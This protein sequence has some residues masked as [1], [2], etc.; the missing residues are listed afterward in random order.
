MAKRCSEMD[1]II[2][3]L[4]P[5]LRKFSTYIDFVGQRKAERIF[6]VIV[7]ASAIIGFC[8]GYITQQLS[9]SIYTLGAGFAVS[10]LLILPPWPF[11]RRNPVHWQPVQTAQTSAPQKEKKKTK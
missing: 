7:V 4:P 2:Q 6:Q 10:C 5:A 11:L 3:M 8:V 1:G 9:H